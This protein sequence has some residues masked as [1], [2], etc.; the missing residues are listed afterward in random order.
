[1]LVTLSGRVALVVLVAQPMAT[2]LPDK[3]VA[4]HF[5]QKAPVLRLFNFRILAS[6]AV[7][8]LADMAVLQG[9]INKTSASMEAAVEVVAVPD[10]LR[11]QVGPAAAAALILATPD[12]LG[13]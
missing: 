10:M 11:E 4:L 6:L 12:R 1:M 13:H 5:M 9:K 7:E 8:A 3:V 2:V